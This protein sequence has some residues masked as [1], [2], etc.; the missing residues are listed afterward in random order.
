[1]QNESIDLDF[2][3]PPTAANRT[4]PNKFPTIASEHRLAIVGEAPGAQ[5]IQA[6]EPF[7]G[8]SG[9]L[10]DGLLSRN[11]ILRSSCFL[12]NVSQHRPPGNDISAFPWTS[13]EIQG[14][15]VKLKEDL[16]AFK[17]N[18]VLALGGTALRALCGDERSILNWRGSLFWSDWGYKTLASLHPAFCIRPPQSGLPLLNF[19]I[20]KAA[21]QRQSPELH[22]PIRQ[23]DLEL[24][25]PELCDHLAQMQHSGLEVS[26][27]IE[28]YVSDLPCLSFSTDPLHGIIV[29]FAKEQGKNHWDTSEEE[30]KVWLA[31]KA[32]L[33]DTSCPKILQN[34]LYDRFV[35]FWSHGI[36][37]RNFKFD[38]MVMH[39]EKYCELKKSLGLQCSIYTN[40]PYYKGDRKAQD[41]KTFR[42]YC[43]K[44]SAVTLE[45]KQRVY[46]TLTTAERAS[47][48]FGMAMQ[49]PLLYMEVRG[50][51]FDTALRDSKVTKLGLEIDVLNA[52][53]TASVG[54]EL[55]VKSPKQKREYLYGTL[56]LP[57][58][59]TRGKTRKVTTNYEAILNLSKKNPDKK[60]L[61]DIIEVTSLRTLRSS[62]GMGVDPDGRVRC[63]YN[64]YKA[65]E[66]KGGP[67]STGRLACSESL[68]GSGTNLQTIP[69]EDT[70]YPEGHLLRPGFRDMF[71]ADE[72]YEM[73]QCDLAGADTWTVA[74]HAKRLGDSLMMEDLLNGIKVAKLLVI[75]IKGNQE[76]MGIKDVPTLKRLCSE[77]SKEDPMYFASKQGIHGTH[78]G[79]K[80]MTLSA[81]IFIESQGKI[82]VPASMCEKIQQLYLRRYPGVLS[83]QRW[84]ANELRTK[85]QIS[86]ASGHTRRFFGNPHEDTV[87]NSAL[88][89]EPQNNTT[90][91]TNRAALNLWLDPENKRPDGS[92]IIEPLHQVH[93]ALVGQWPV[94]VRDWAKAKVRSYFNNELTIAGLRLVIPFSGQF[95][96]NWKEAG[97]E[98]NPNVI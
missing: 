61:V 6:G 26:I 46:P 11:N 41:V 86:S 8:P 36:L 16:R 27:D 94:G 58:Q 85:R 44:D 75:A 54:K 20:R 69:D 42:T 98:K 7:V 45:I 22:L 38:T 2:S 93:D 50:I 63:S 82:N 23:F 77:V 19:D 91:A 90:Y 15:I 64:S 62:L 1:M 59:F 67:T 28:G 88:S 14:G 10:L 68:T 5:E 74:A 24:T 9:R 87:L 70:N 25:Q 53:V 72:G 60:E 13:E 89:D 57:E 83:W 65:D 80:K 76:V 39:W 49:D 18:L 21:L 92:L 48:E 71:L 17:P 33:E 29:P 52:Q 81:R 35:L 32:I 96:K 30:G 34:G 40:E 43:C 73:F 37:I 78:Y 84:V 97:D 31:V 55:N 56:G 95:G 47:F 79:M 3:G 12:G 4:V 51:R 66:D